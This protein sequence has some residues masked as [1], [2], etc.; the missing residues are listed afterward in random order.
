MI[1]PAAVASSNVCAPSACSRQSNQPQ[2][3]HDIFVQQEERRSAAA[4]QTELVELINDIVQFVFAL[5]FGRTQLLER[6]SPWRLE[7]L[8]KQ[9][10][11]PATSYRQ[12]CRLAKLLKVLEWSQRGEGCAIIA[13]IKRLATAHC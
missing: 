5:Q 8:R 3:Q 12:I 13:A 9:I 6:I 4:S 7:L 10:P 2:L 11:L 1:E